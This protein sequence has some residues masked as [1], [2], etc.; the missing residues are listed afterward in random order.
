MLFRSPEILCDDGTM[1]PDD[2]LRILYEAAVQGLGTFGCDALRPARL[3]ETL[4]RAGY[5]NIHRVTHKIPV[6]T[7]AHGRR[8]K[9]LGLFMKTVMLE[10][11]DA[12]AAKPLAALD[13]SPRDRQ[14]L[15]G[16]V[17]RSLADG[18]VHR[19]VNC[20]FCYGQKRE[21]AGRRQQEEAEGCAADHDGLWL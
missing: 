13:M 16:H 3:E 20:V 11:L 5:T 19:Y 10:S 14:Q 6:S 7:W 15:V 21:P 2:P 1:K 17:V 18:S 9:T 8:L 4:E 12:W